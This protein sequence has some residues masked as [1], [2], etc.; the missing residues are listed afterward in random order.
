MNRVHLVAIAVL[1]GVVFWAGVKAQQEVQPRPGPGSGLMNVNILNRPAVLAEQIGEWQVSVGRMPDV[2]IA[3]TPTVAVRLPMFAARGSKYI[4]TWA[5]GE[6]DRVSISDVGEDGWVQV[7]NQGK[8]R[9]WINL[10]NARA[11]EEA[12]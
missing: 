3:N 12:N 4:V 5:T 11:I 6:I 7:D 2:R 8:N 9:R 10:R 1:A